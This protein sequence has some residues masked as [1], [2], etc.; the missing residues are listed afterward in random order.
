MSHTLKILYVTCDS[1][2][3]AENLCRTLV[4]ER[5]IACGNI[6]PGVRSIYRY[7][8]KIHEDSEAAVLMKTS[9]EKAPAAMKRITELHSYDIPAVEVWAVED[10]PEPFRKWV[11][12]E[13]S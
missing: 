8:G 5:L 1:V 7:Q 9:A 2:E 13:T 12:E 10:A 6:I 4:S 11:L 3:R